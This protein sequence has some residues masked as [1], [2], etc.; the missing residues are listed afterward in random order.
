MRN[1]LKIQ[2][3]IDQEKI[4]TEGEEGNTLYIVKEGNVAI[5]SNGQYLR[6][7]NVN[8]YFGERSLFFNEPRSATAFAIGST[9]LYVLESND[10]KMI[11]ED[12]LKRFLIQRLALQ[13]DKITLNDL[14]YLKQLGAGS[15]GSVCLVRSK[16]TKNFYAIKAMNKKQID[17]EKLHENIEMEKGILLKIDHPFIVKLV[18]TLKDQNNIFFL[19]EYVRG[20]ELWDVIREIGLLSKYQTQFYGASLLHAIDYLHERKIIY[21]DIK[22]ENIMVAENVKISFF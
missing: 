11:L 16:R 15:F 4:I 19:M 7:L 14:D 5:H 18:K 17:Y 3:Y 1:K 13:D 2:T 6:T 21:R 9:V 20:K 12:N 22:P 8:E 10:L